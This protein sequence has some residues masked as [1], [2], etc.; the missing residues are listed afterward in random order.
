MDE[1]T[2]AAAA[3]EESGQ[4]QTIKAI[5]GLRGM[6]I[7]GRLKPGERVLEQMLVD[8]L[9]VSRTP[10]RSAILRVCEEGLIESLP[11]GGFAVASFS[12]SDVFDAIAVRGNLEGMA[13]RV[14]AERGA[15]SAV[16]QRMWRCVDDLDRVIDGLE[17]SPDVTEYV[18][19]NDRFHELLIDAAQS[20]M[21]RKSLQ[22]I[23]ALPFAA[24]NAFVSISHPDLVGVRKI[25]QVSQEQH[26][27]MVDAI[28]R[29]EGARVEALALEHSRSAWKYL[30]L[31]FDAEEELAR[32]PGMNLVVRRRR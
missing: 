26:R 19:L 4:S 29:R 20:N 32:V 16:L 22:R 24:P 14:A 13:G 23:T 15:P 2:T 27:S 30:R 17:T 12:E 31:I 9:S 6:I 28:E 8:Q 3:R 25:L 10:A 7:E 21:I 1:S 5:L 11:S 18:R